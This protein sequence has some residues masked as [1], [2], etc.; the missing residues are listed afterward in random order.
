MLYSYRLIISLFVLAAPAQA[1]IPLSSQL[2]IR[3][4]YA[5]SRHHT[6]RQLHA[7]RRGL[8][9]VLA[10]RGGDSSDSDDSSDI[11]FSLDDESD[12][13]DELE[14]DDIESASEEQE[15]IQPETTAEP[16]IGPV[17]LTIKTNLDCPISDQS[18]EFTASG[19]RT[20]ES[21]KQ[22]KWIV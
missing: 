16:S 19:K 6:P 12:Q 14:A 1:R 20:V 4:N 7:S 3:S 10:I 22:G 17:K 21:L 9:G 15:G 8:F 5:A 18:L 2:L 11:E 13:N